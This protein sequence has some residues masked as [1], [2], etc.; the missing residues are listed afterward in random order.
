MGGLETYSCKLPTSLEVVFTW[1]RVAEGG[2][3]DDANVLCQ[4]EFASRSFADDK[5]SV[6]GGPDQM[7]A[8]HL[9]CWGGLSGAG[10]DILC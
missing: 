7:L 2:D 1:S 4:E 6:K 5:Y 9:T 8:A 3:R 10:H